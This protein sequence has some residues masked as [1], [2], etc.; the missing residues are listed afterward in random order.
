MRKAKCLVEENYR[1]AEQAWTQLQRITNDRRA[2]S[3]VIQNVNVQLRLTDRKRQ[4]RNCESVAQKLTTPGLLEIQTPPHLSIPHPES[5]EVKQIIS[6]T[7]FSLIYWNES[8][9]C[10]PTISTVLQSCVRRYYNAYEGVICLW[11]YGNPS[12]GIIMSRGFLKLPAPSYSHLIFFPAVKLIIIA[13]MVM[14]LSPLFASTGATVWS[15]CWSRAPEQTCG[16]SRNILLTVL[17]EL[18]VF[19]N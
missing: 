13:R 8:T 1:D 4:R 5:Y 16:I 12:E 10:K 11:R 19:D 7:Y 14:N 18:E 9:G 15:K 2:W 3:E 17:I 6:K